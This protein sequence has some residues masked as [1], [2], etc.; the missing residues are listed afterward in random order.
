MGDQLSIFDDSTEQTHAGE[1][2]AH[3][4]VCSS[5]FIES[6][7]FMVPQTQGVGSVRLELFDC[8]GGRINEVECSYP[9][10][11]VGVLELDQLLGACKLE[12]GVKHAHIKVVSNGVTP[13]LR[14][15][16]K[17]GAFLVGEPVE[18]SSKRPTFF[19]LSFHER[20][21]SYLCLVN[22]EDREVT[23]KCRLFC[24]KRM[25]E[26]YSVVPAFGSRMICLN[27]EFKDY[28]P[29][30]GETLVP[31]YVRVSTGADN[32]CGI[33]LLEQVIS[34]GAETYFGSV[35]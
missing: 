14:M 24:A 26:A 3:F 20:R 13:Q 1:R 17:T 21:V 22:Q 32:G 8:D 11:E 5:P 12:S 27:T 6:A 29:I 23:I 10:G 16:S 19:P 30:E 28:L 15:F 4:W 18:I 35:S 25:P 31:A 2:V 9:P 34:S 7:L 33:Q